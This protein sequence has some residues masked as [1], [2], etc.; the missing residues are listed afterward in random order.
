MST[1]AAVPGPQPTALSQ[2]A[3]ILNTFTSPAKTFND[4]RRKSGWVVPWLLISLVSLVFIWT[5]DQKIGFEQ[6]TRNLMEKSPRG[7]QLEKLPP[8]QR[9]QQ[10][11][12]IIQFT[13]AVS[14]LSPIIALLIYVIIALVLMATFNF[15]AGAEVPVKT[16]LGIVTYG[17]LP[18]IIGAVLGIVSLLAGM[19]AEG[20]N[21]NN[22]VATNP[23]YFMDPLA[24]P[25]LYGMASALD[26]FVIW[27]IILIAI[28]FACNS[29]LTRTA[30]LSVV[31]GW[32]LL[33]KLVASGMAA[34]FA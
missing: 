6:V 7:V 30:T 3:R 15:G 1:A 10:L 14:Y 18:M 26:I 9:A 29:K 28:G 16:A 22:P 33:Y 4:L 5:L 12:G 8:D 2:P 20:F 25:F 21:L 17:V 34:L 19:N 31:G 24:S 27:S 13:K 32:Y 11:R 23:A